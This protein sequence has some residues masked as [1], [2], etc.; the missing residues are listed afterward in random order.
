MSLLKKALERLT[1]LLLKSGRKSM[2]KSETSGVEESFYTFCCQELHPSMLRQMQRWRRKFW[3]D[4][5]HWQAKRGTRS[6]MK[7]KTLSLNSSPTT[8]TNESVQETHLHTLG[9]PKCEKLS[10]MRRLRREPSRI[11][12]SSEPKRR[13][14]RPRSLTSRVSCSRRRKRKALQVCSRLSTK[15][16][17]ECCRK[18]KSRR[19]TK[20]SS[21]NRWTKTRSTNYLQQLTLMGVGLLITP[22]SW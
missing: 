10:S 19:D 7:P 21:A 15:T 5:T 8:K 17:M 3:M 11:S 13:S 18:K 12:P 20:R 2:M 4:R 9:S 6:Q 14:S 16:E 1:I 22:N